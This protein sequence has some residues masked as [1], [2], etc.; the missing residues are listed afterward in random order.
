[1]KKESFTQVLLGAKPMNSDLDDKL[2]TI[3]ATKRIFS[4]IHELWKYPEPSRGY[5]VTSPPV[6]KGVKASSQ[7][8]VNQLELGQ[9]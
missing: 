8:R 4:K 2:A 3:L 5:S 7:K 1:D 9:K 6:G